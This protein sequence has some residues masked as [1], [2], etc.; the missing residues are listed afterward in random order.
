MAARPLVRAR[1][2]GA[3]IA[4]V[5]VVV[6]G[7][8]FWA[9]QRGAFV[10]GP[11]RALHAPINDSTVVTVGDARSWGP[12]GAMAPARYPGYAASDKL[13][14]CLRRGG[15]VTGIFLRDGKRIRLWHQSPDER[16]MLPI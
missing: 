16:L 2:I 3:G 13:A 14:L 7:G 4:V 8:L 15:D 1:R 5:A 10:G 11:C 9:W 6:A 12:G